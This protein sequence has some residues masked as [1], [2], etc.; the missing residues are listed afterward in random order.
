M[1]NV[2]NTTLAILNVGFFRT[3]N[4]ITYYG[5]MLISSSLAGNRFLNFFLGSIVEYPAAAV[6]LY[7]ITR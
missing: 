6:E 5:I 2:H 4:S 1:E 3:T 7:L